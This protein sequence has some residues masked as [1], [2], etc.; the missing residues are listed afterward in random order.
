MLNE[1]TKAY[2][3][4]HQD[5]DVRK[6]ALK[7]PT[8]DR[9]DFRM[10]LQQIEGRQIARKKLP[11]WCQHEDILFPPRLSLEQCSSEM[12][13][14]YKQA[15]AKRLLSQMTQKEGK[16]LVDLTGGLG[17]DFSY[18]APLFT[19][20]VYMERQ[21]ELCLLARHNMAVLGLD[22]AEVIATD[23][24][25][26]PADWPEADICFVD[27]ARRDTAGRKIVA[28]SD[29]EPDLS[30]LQD[31][32]REKMTYCIFKLSPLLDIRQAMKELTHI[33]EIH[34]VSVQ[35][36]CKELLMVMSSRPVAEPVK[37]YCVN[38]KPELS[39][40]V[41]IYNEEQTEDCAYTS[42]LRTYLY[43]PNSSV[44]KAGAFRSIGRQYGLLK[45]HPNSH[46]YT[47]DKLIAHFPGR[48][49]IIE[50]CSSFSRTDVRKLLSGVSKAN[51]TIRNF[52]SDVSALRKRLHLKDGG[53]VY[54]FVTTLSDEQHVIIK[55]RKVSGI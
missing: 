37:C 17:I 49:F 6:L 24:A 22:Q 34:V 8:D 33:V 15:L 14:L 16:T 41:F 30:R 40:F 47:S 44:L 9:I 48:I 28:I 18:L 25:A 43:E 5:E 1:E 13:A 35:N 52:P 31:I 39:E 36:E 19:K 7:T 27:P 20:A 10:A 55:T 23:S 32:L 53:D 3:L 29:C 12:T 42:E 51:I 38:L 54:L 50:G 2:I 11:A 45:L 4:K 46:L 26:H 21:H